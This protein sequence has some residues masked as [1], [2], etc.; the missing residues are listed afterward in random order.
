ME[1]WRNDYE[2][3]ADEREKR[4]RERERNDADT[5]PRLSLVASL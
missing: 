1:W 4:E 5:T 3:K 2:G